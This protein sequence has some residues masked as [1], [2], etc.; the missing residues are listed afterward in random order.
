LR[1]GV[2]AVVVA[3][4]EVD[5]V[6]AGEFAARLYT[7][8]LE[9][10]PYGDAV[11]IARLEAHEADGGS[12]NTWGA[13]QCY[14]DPSF[15]LVANT[16]S[17][18]RKPSIVSAAQ[19][20]R[21]FNLAAARAGDAMTDAHVLGV[22]QDVERLRDEGAPFLADGKALEALGEALAE[23]GRY[24][25]AIA[26]YREA[27][28]DEQAVARLHTAEQLANLLA[29]RT[30]AVARSPGAAAN[31]DD[32]AAAFDEAEGLLDSVERLAGPSAERHALHGSVRK[33]RATTLE[34]AARR[35]MLERARDSYR[36]AWM[37][38]SNNGQHLDGYHTNVWLQLSG[39]TNGTIDADQQAHL[40]ALYS[41][42]T[43][44]DAL[45]TDYWKVAASADTLLTMWLVGHTPAGT[46]VTI[47]MVA[48]E[49]KK[50]FE[51]R[52]TVRQ[53]NSVIEHLEDLTDLAPGDE[54]KQLHELVEELRG[55][56]EQERHAN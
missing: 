54:H 18:S 44:P 30:A 19:L 26:A 11:R 48:N 41:Q 34:G 31:G 3:G 43:A 8:L 7:A 2:G 16:P 45:P 12:T 56:D 14:G 5:D 51:L 24:D 36:D 10:C 29:R 25:D 32:V 46:P 55:V 52:S 20:V 33:K 35:A 37:L 49:Y 38:S 1:N 42:C 53:R 39:L 9:G 22:L 17:S 13:Y 27:L 23:L 21:S 28:T 6:A 4:W 40:D 50:A 15:E 47:E